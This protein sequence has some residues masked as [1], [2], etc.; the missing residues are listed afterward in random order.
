[1]SRRH[2]DFT[3]ERELAQMRRCRQSR[4]ASPKEF[5]VCMKEF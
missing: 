5:L 1:M 2:L 4:N 3:R